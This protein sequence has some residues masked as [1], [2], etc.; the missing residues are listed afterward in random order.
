MTVKTTMTATATATKTMIA[1]AKKATTTTTTRWRQPYTDSWG[2]VKSRNWPDLTPV[3]GGQPDLYNT[4]RTSFITTSRQRPSSACLL[5]R[6]LGYKTTKI[7]KFCRGEHLVTHLVVDISSI[8][9]YYHTMP[10]SLLGFKSKVCD[11]YSC[12]WWLCGLL[13]N[14]VFRGMVH[15]STDPQTSKPHT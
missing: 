8:T 13:P 3:T 2:P 6:S 7:C 11:R 15:A 12:N 4:A 9:D 5:L 14:T 1:T 10:P